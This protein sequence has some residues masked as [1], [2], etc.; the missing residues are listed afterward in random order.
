MHFL[1]HI[2]SMTIPFPQIDPVLVQL[3]PLAI[4]WYSLAYI[5]G[6]VLGWMLVKRELAKH[7]LA[8]LTK[9]RMEDMVMW[10]IGGIIIGGRLGYTLFYKPEYYFANP[11]QI[12]HVWEGGM[13]FHGGFAGFAIAFYFFCR[14]H[15]IAYLKLMDLMACVAPIGLGL[16]RIANFV[17]GELWGRETRVPWAMVFPH[18]D[19][20][21]RHP[22]QLYEAALEG[23]LLLIIMLCL[24]NYS[25]LRERAGALCG[26]FLMGYALARI[27]CEF[28]REPDVQLGFLWEGATM[29]QLLSVPMMLLGIFL[30]VRAKR[31]VA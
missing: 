17:N 11:M 5:G 20:L 26:V 14:K 29:G 31:N 12:L 4:R 23:V 19:I 28:F 7:P 24:L 10:A 27:A 1:S 13:S 8:G 25:K 21:P 18:A 16:G 6:V 3:G 22:S 15:G 9:A 2:D 30:Y